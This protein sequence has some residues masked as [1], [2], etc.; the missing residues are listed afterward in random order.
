MHTDDYRK[1]SYLDVQV[2]W[3]NGQWSTQ[4]IFIL[5]AYNNKQLK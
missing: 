4:A 5:I 1:Q 2:S 3:I